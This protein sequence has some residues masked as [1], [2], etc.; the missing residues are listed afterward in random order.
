MIGDRVLWVNT[1]LLLDGFDGTFRTGPRC[2]LAFDVDLES[3]ERQVDITERRCPN[4]MPSLP[5]Y[6]SQTTSSVSYSTL[7]ARQ[8]KEVSNYREEVWDRIYQPMRLASLRR[9]GDSA[10]FSTNC[11]EEQWIFNIWASG[12]WSRMMM[13]AWTRIPRGD[14]FRRPTVVIF[15]AVSCTRT[16][17]L[18]SSSTVSQ[19][20]Q[21]LHHA[22]SG[23]F[24]LL[25]GY[26]AT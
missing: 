7:S 8:E 4:P 19:P 17:F 14:F 18:Y 24:L 25:Q 11:N 16:K 23:K 26:K 22:A 12:A 15:L 9:R 6:Q 5:L 3:S 13:C 20:T 21:S 1:Y 10:D 2:P